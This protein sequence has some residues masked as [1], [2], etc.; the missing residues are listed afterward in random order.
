MS[1]KGTGAASH[2]FPL[3]SQTLASRVGLQI[4]AAQRTMGLWPRA[5]GQKE[6]EHGGK[7]LGKVV[8]VGGA[9]GKLLKDPGTLQ[10]RGHPPLCPEKLGHLGQLQNL[11][12]LH[13]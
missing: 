13:P 11:G 4:F 8:A 5:Q 7:G 2:T 6:H 9:Y 10:A 12:S 1:S 3:S